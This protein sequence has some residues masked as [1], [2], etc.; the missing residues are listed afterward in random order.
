MAA[1]REQ[2]LSRSN[3]YDVLGHPTGKR[4]LRDVQDLLKHRKLNLRCDAPTEALGNCFPY[5]VMQQLHREEIRSTLTD[6][7]KVL[8]MD[9]QSLREGIVQFVRNITPESEYFTLIDESRTS[10]A[11][12]ALDAENNLPD[13]NSRLHL[14][15]TDRKWF[16]A[17]FIQF[18][19][20][21]LQ[22]DIICYATSGNIK[23]CGSPTAT[24]G[25]LQ[26]DHPCSCSGEPLLIANIR[27]AH[28]QSLLPI[29]PS[30]EQLSTNS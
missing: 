22:R 29:Q 8:S 10:W 17:Q 6:E 20:C 3:C 21:F 9:C 12:I 11:E 27:N 13:W 5:A 26:P 2:G 30:N 7:M 16:D 15:E 25:D 23:F 19:S 28:F 14:M 18:T 4:Y 1:L 24:V